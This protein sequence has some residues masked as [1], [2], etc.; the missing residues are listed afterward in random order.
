GWSEFSNHSTRQ[1]LISAAIRELDQNNKYLTDMDKAYEQIS[2]LDQVYL[3]PTFYYNG[4]QAIQ[5][6]PLFT[7]KDESLLNSV[8]SYLYNVNPTNDSILKLNIIFSGKSSS[9]Q[10]K[11]ETYGSFYNSKL[12]QRFRKKHEDLQEQLIKLKRGSVVVQIGLRLM[13]VVSN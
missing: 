2:N 8:S 13:T 11:K 4:I 6:S 10:H 7:K 12:L 5:A 1:T 3:L 9:L